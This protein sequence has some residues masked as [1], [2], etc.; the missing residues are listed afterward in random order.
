MI[1][2]DATASDTADGT[3]VVLQS[4]EGARCKFLGTVQSHVRKDVEVAEKALTSVL[5]NRDRSI[6]VT[7]KECAGV[8]VPASFSIPLGRIHPGPEAGARFSIVLPS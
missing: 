2:R 7:S 5:G 4:P 6:S 3:P 8:V 1:V